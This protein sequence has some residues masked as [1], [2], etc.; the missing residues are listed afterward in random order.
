MGGLLQR[1]LTTE[2]AESAERC[3]F[4]VSSVRSVVFQNPSRKI[5]KGLIIL[6]CN[7]IGEVNP[8][9]QSCVIPVRFVSVFAR[10]FRFVLEVEICHPDFQ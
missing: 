10:F 1:R 9:M 4:S 2:D 8:F 5:I 6:I 3:F 7:I